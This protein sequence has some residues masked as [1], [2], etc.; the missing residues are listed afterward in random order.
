MAKRNLPTKHEVESY[1]RNNRNWGRWGDKGAAG[2]INLI[3]PDKRLAATKLVK[4][5]RAVS[6]SRP[7]STTPSPSNPYPTQHYVT[8]V[9]IGSDG[10]GCS[11]YYGMAYH[12]SW[13]TTHI[14]ALSHNWNQDGMWDG[15]NPDEEISSSSSGYGSVDNFSDGILTRGVLLDVPKHRGKPYVTQNDPVHGWELEDIVKK[16]DVTL[17]PGDALVVYSNREGYVKDHGFW[18]PAPRPGL[19]ASCLPFIRENDVSILVWDMMDAKPN[20]YTEMPIIHMAINAYGVVLL[21]NA[22]LAPLAEVCA[23]EERYEFMITI[24]P[25]Y[26]IGGTG[27]PVN[28]IALF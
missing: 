15:R 7:L 17:E 19:H 1:L 14:D 25:L 16:Q 26:V 24:N 27:S 10:G 2:A 4:T 6:L 13:E 18:G 21:D 12:Q 11:D 8:K 3:T 5:G 9:E 20:A 22:L 28:P 23:K